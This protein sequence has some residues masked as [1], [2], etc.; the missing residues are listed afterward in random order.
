VSI[1][2]SFN[3]LHQRNYEVSELVHAEATANADTIARGTTIKLHCSLSS[4][5]NRAISLITKP[6]R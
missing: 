5:D 3:A 4:I 6:S 2:S 1:Y